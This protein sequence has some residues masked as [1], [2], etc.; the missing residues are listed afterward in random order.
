[1]TKLRMMLAA[2]LFAAG[3][4]T[5]PPPP[6]PTAAEKAAA[7]KGTCFCKSSSCLCSHCSIGKGDCNCPR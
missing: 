2:V 7:P 4:Q 6:A 3:C 5:P 1:M